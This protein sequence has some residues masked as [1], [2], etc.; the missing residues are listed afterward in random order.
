MVATK[1]RIWST[2]VAGLAAFLLLT[3]NATAVEVWSVDMQGAGSLDFGQED[4]PVLAWGPDLVFGQGL[5]WN[6]FDVPG[7]ALPAAFDPTMNLVDADGFPSPVNFSITGDVAGFSNAPG[8]DPLWKDYLFVN[9]GN[10]GPSLNW[11]ITGLT[12]DATYDMINYG[13]V[14]RLATI[15]VDVDG[16]G[17]LTNDTPRIAPTGGASIL[18]NITADATGTIIG[19]MGVGSTAEENWGGFQLMRASDTPVVGTVW[20]V[21]MQGVGGIVSKPEPTTMAGEENNYG[22]GDVWNALNIEGHPNVSVAPEMD[23]VDSHGNLTPVHLAFQGT[24]SSWSQ[25]G[26]PLINDYLFVNAGNADFDALWEISGLTPGGS[27]EMFAYGGVARDAAITVDLNGDGALFDEF[28]SYVTGAGHLFAD[29][30]ADVTGTIRG[31]V[32]P[33]NA[34]EANWG[35]FQLRDM[36]PAPMPTTLIW[37]GQS[38][39]QWSE[40]DGGTGLSRWTDEFGTQQ[41]VI[42]D[43]DAITIVRANTVEV[44]GDGVARSLEVESGEIQVTGSLAI[45]QTVDVH[46]GASMAL[47]ANATASAGT[48]LTFGSGSSLTLDA[49][50][51]LTGSSLEV[52]TGSTMTLGQ[53]ALLS[54]RKDVAVASGTTLQIGPGATLQAEGG[55]V[56]AA[57]FTAGSVI[58]V[59][60]LLQLNSLSDGAAADALLIKRG[61]GTLVTAQG[62]VSTVASTAVRIEEGTLVA[63]GSDP[64]GGATA[65]TMAGGQLE[66]NAV[67]EPLQAWDFESGDLTGW[68]LVDTVHGDNAVFATFG[69]QPAMLPHSGTYDPTTVQGTFWIRTW[70]GES[71]GTGDG[72]TGIVETDSFVLGEGAQIDLLIGGGN[73]PFSGD[74]DTPGANITA[75]NLERLVGPDDWE[76]I[77]STNGANRNDLL[78]VRWNAPDYAGETVRLRIYDTASGGWGHVAADNIVLSTVAELDLADT[79]VLL[80]ASSTITANPGASFG[81]LTINEGTL[82]TVG[83]SSIGFTAT[84]IDLAPGVAEIGFN[85]QVATHLGAVTA[86]GITPVTIAKT[87]QADLIL[88]KGGIG[89]GNVTFEAREGR[90]VGVHDGSNPFGTAGLQLG[91][92]EIVLSS[93]GGDATYENSLSI[94]EDGTLRAGATGTIT[95]VEITLGGNGPGVD[96]PD[97]RT[98]TLTAGDGYTLN[99]AGDLSGDGNV[100]VENGSVTLSGAASSIGSMT[101]MG[102]TLSTAGNAVSISNRVDLGSSSFSIE[103]PDSFAISGSDLFDAEV[104][105]TVTL[106]GGKLTVTPSSGLIQD[107]DADVGVTNTFDGVSLWENQAPSGGDDV[108]QF[109]AFLMPQ[110]RPGTLNGHNTI[111]FLDDFDGT[112]DRMFGDDRDAFDGLIDGT[113]HTWFVVAKVGDQLDGSDLNRFFGTLTEPDIPGWTGISPGVNI[114]GVPYHVTRAGGNDFAWG[115]Q[116]ANDGQFHIFAGRLAKGTGSGI[117]EQLFVDDPAAVGSTGATV[118]PGIDSDLL[119]IGVERLTGGEDFLGEIARIMIFDRPLGDEELNDTGAMLAQQYGLTTAFQHSGS[120]P[121]MPNTHFVLTSDTEMTATE[122]FVELGDLTLPSG[123]GTLKLSNA[124]FSFHDVTVAEGTLIDGAIAVRGVLAPEAASRT[125]R[126][127]GD[128]TILDD[129]TLAIPID[130]TG[131]G[132][133]EALLDVTFSEESKLQFVI[134]GKST[135]L[136]GEYTLITSFGEQGIEGTFSEILGLGQYVTNGGLTYDPNGETVTLTIDKNL[137][138]GDA[139]LDTTTDVR[140][141]NVWNTNK[142][143]SGTDWTTGDFD[144]N[145]VT[146]VRDFNVWNTSKFTSAAAGPP[147]GGQVP[148]PGTLVLLFGG[149]LGLLWAGRH[150]MSMRRR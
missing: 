44:A 29:I 45:T 84:T 52:A 71:L 100:Y 121:G 46:D 69:N 12:P 65:I 130:A 127:D 61:S 126:V 40:I 133:L 7:H 54:I 147:I 60:G 139:T 18:R 101:V 117:L 136:A 109:D 16:N 34:S 51:E 148:E 150:R 26:T 104:G 9:A 105:R 81:T 123:S 113:G 94:V 143:T 22:L 32:A 108:A 118:L 95:P 89:L 119:S 25:E 49:G 132:R 41:T 70:E 57:T 128:V 17:D 129:A 38:D 91:G 73:H 58:D 64:L 93:T 2:A 35:G 24:V 11:S 102:G 75:V 74:P 137:H 47:G 85:P 77:F 66:L 107:L 149:V 3:G 28:S 79:D 122:V 103:A 96:I 42:P 36:N 92:G 125:I 120:E 99:V 82:T 88:D 83:G 68:N 146:D 140:D 78:P 144:G 33:G 43:V 97:G 72:P 21:D 59:A 19:D 141:F 1:H 27:Y 142:F 31:S 13:G 5:I 8:G 116:S 6:A 30:T 138:P 110:L 135:F 53:G 76:M 124:L 115:T 112:G 134:N 10:A 37:D 23:L 145:G 50:A 15:T 106:S 20:S 90:L 86:D 4:P 131:T 14:A 48:D 63:S 80:T 114:D 111:E 56:D 87:G 62:G 67:V 39:G 55:T 98:L